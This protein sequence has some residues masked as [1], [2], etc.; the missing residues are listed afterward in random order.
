MW[1]SSSHKYTKQKEKRDRENREKRLHIHIHKQNF[2]CGAALFTTTPAGSK[3]KFKELYIYIYKYSINLASICIHFC[4]PLVYIGTEMLYITHFFIIM[5]AAPLPL[6]Q[7]AK[8]NWGSALALF[9]CIIHGAVKIQMAINHQHQPIVQLPSSGGGLW[10]GIIIRIR[11]Y[12]WW[13]QQSR[14]RHLPRTEYICIHW[15][16]T[17]RLVR[18][19]DDNKTV[20]KRDNLFSDSKRVTQLGWF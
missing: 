4:V 20:S 12:V 14:L 13:R 2:E 5:Y 10:A 1:L 15:N 3:K 8:F 7:A 18:D 6:L 19:D 16:L 11:R 17:M 9:F